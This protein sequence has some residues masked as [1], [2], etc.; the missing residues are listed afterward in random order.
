MSEEEWRE[1]FLH[2]VRNALRAGCMT[3]GAAPFLQAMDRMKARPRWVQ[4][5]I[6]PK[7]KVASVRRQMEDAQRDYLAGE[8]RPERTVK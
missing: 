5:F 4:D 1:A 3:E 7:V 6:H 2:G 8:G